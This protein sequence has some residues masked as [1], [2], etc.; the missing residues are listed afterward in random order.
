MADGQRGEL[1]PHHRCVDATS[2]AGPYICASKPSGQRH[3][4]LLL[5]RGPQL[6][7]RSSAGRS[8]ALGARDPGC[9]GDPAQHCCECQG[10]RQRQILKQRTETQDCAGW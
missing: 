5:E 9:T 2:P 1:D 3:K 6:S 7:L 8:L 10:G 4:V